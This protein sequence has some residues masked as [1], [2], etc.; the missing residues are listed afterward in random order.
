LD[1][2]QAQHAA[3]FYYGESL[4]LLWL[5]LLF[6]MKVRLKIQGTASGERGVGASLLF[7]PEGAADAHKAKQ[8]L[9]C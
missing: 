9:P 1:E 6:E 4:Q 5:T 8:V 7:L 3:C 2:K